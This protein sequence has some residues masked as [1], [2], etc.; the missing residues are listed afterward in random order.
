MENKLRSV[1][2]KQFE[3][4]FGNLIQEYEIIK[5]H[6]NSNGEWIEDRRF[7][8]SRNYYIVNN[9]LYHRIN[10]SLFLCN[11]DFNSSTCGACYQI[12]KEIINNKKIIGN[13]I[14]FT[15]VCKLDNQSLILSLH[16]Q[17]YS[18]NTS[19]YSLRDRY[20]NFKLEYGSNNIEDLIIQ[21]E[22]E[23]FLKERYIKEQDET[24]VEHLKKIYNWKIN[25]FNRLQNIQIK[26]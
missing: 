2:F 12:G 17:S 25:I 14:L 5:Y 18:D 15:E 8:S 3:D 20:N 11:M 9:N 16:K 22:K 26:Y 1:N 10:D 23:I 4:N 13:K 6:K 21:I 19:F 7:N 24:H